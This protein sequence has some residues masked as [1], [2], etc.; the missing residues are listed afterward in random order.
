MAYTLSREIT[1]WM[2][3]RLLV[4]LP[5]PT[6]VLTQVDAQLRL[7]CGYFGFPNNFKQTN[8]W[9]GFLKIF[10]FFFCKVSSSVTI[11]HFMFYLRHACVK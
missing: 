1:H 5:D 8:I 9:L 7:S 6:L 11:K 4:S 2:E 3:V 10:F